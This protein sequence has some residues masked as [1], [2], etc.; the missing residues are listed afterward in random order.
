MGEQQFRK[1]RTW[2]YPKETETLIP[3]LHLMMRLL[4]KSRKAGLNLGDSEENCKLLQSMEDLVQRGYRRGRGEAHIISMGGCQAASSATLAR[5]R[6]RKRELWLQ[7]SLKK[8]AE[9][10]MGMDSGMLL[11]G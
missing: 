10:W 2:R 3:S 8:K 4:S 6:L 7:Y 1:L 9:G 11:E 5:A